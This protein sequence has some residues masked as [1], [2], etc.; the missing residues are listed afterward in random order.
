MWYKWRYR[1]C[2]DCWWALFCRVTL[3]Q[4]CFLLAGF[5]FSKIN[6]FFLHQFT[7]VGVKRKQSRAFLCLQC[8]FL[9]TRKG[10]SCTVGYIYL[11]AMAENQHDAA[12]P[13]AFPS[14]VAGDCPAGPRRKQSH[15]VAL[16]AVVWLVGVTSLGMCMH[17]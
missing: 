3:C 4:G 13:K 11:S 17:L 12:V 6:C 7:A 14:A 10:L 2:M 5:L 16:W 1:H 9:K 15:G 8:Y